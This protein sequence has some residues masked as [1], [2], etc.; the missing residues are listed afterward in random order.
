MPGAWESDL[1]KTSAGDKPAIGVLVERTTRL[2]LLA[3]M[4][5]ATATSALA[6]FTFKLNQ[7]G[8]PRYWIPTKRLDTANLRRLPITIL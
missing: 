4:P 3:K 1:I 6:A 2:L 5:D 8:K 7:I